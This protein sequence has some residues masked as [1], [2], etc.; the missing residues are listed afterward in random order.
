MKISF[1]SLLLI[2]FTNI[3]YTLKCT[4]KNVLPV[5]EIPPLPPPQR[6]VSFEPKIP[7]VPEVIK[8]PR[9]L[10][11]TI[12][13]EN[14]EI[15]AL[16]ELKENDCED[17]ETSD[18][19]KFKCVLSEDR[20]KC[21]E[22][23]K[24]LNIPNTYDSIN[25]DELPSSTISDELSSSYINSDELSSSSISDEL[26]SSTISDELSS[27][28]ISDKLSSSSNSDELHSS[29][30]SDEI[31]SLN[32]NEVLNVSNSSVYINSSIPT[33]SSR[34]E[35]I[36]NPI[37]KK[38]NS[39]LSTGAI[40]AIAIPTIAALLGVATVAALFT[41]TPPPVSGFTAPSLPEPN[42]VDTSLEKFRF[43]NDMPIQQPQPP[44]PVQIIEQPRPIQI[45][46][47]QEP[48]QSTYPLNR[49]IEPPR[50]NNVFQQNIMPQQVQMVP[51]Q[52]VQMVPIEEV[53]MVPVQQI[54]MAPIQ[55]VVPMNQTIPIGQVTEAV[56]QVAEVSTIPGT[57][58]IPQGQLS[59]ELISSSSEI[60]PQSQV[61][62]SQ[63]IPNI[64]QGSQVLSSQELPVQVLPTIDHG[65]QVLP[66]KVLPSVD[67]GF[68]P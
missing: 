9:H 67:Q 50:V 42:Y 30:N 46:P 58:V 13:D 17:L 22:I 61:L 59:N 31:T 24:D 25:S 40:C 33:S 60:I 45:E 1:I 55:Q 35:T 32:T 2:A 63:V 53:Q 36:N 39:G 7:R 20:T 4:E 64:D 47:M 19:S 27:S 57:E 12:H 16:Q 15:R 23:S 54:G 37:F 10:E 49:V 48:P 26:H 14:V 29:I 5:P 44:Q 65:V 28:T 3:S 34:N 52:E 6:R 51:V 41:G 56:P 68:L 66:T 38:S 11:A 62:T 8:E 21:V 18:D 43:V